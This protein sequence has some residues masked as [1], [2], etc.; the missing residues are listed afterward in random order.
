V[1]QVDRRLGKLEAIRSKLD[2]LE[3]SNQTVFGPDDATYGIVTWGS[4]QGAAAEAVE[5]LNDRGES[6]KGLGVSELMPFPRREV[7]D[8]LKSVDQALVVEMNASGQFRG[9]TQKELGGFGDR[10]SSLLKYDG[11]PFEPEEI[12]EGFELQLLE[13]GEEAPTANTRLVPAMGD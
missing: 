7:S 8:F 4:T 3:P 6:V 12:V 1:F 13:D 5:R 9:L 10:M 11:N 2:G